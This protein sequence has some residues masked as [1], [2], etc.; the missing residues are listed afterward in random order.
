M[1]ANYSGLYTKIPIPSGSSSVTRTYV[2]KKDRSAYFWFRFEANGPHI[3]IYCTRHPSLYG[4]DPSP[5]K[6]HLL[7]SGKLC[8]VPGHEPQSQAEA[9]ARAGA[10]AEYWVEYTRCGEPQS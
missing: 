7:D 10:W 6:T 5:G 3:D 4:R 8:F 9:E 2:S 1:I